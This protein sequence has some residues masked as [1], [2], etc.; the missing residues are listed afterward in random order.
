MSTWFITGSSSGLGRQLALAVLDAGHN[1]VV[2]A[3]SVDSVKDLADIHPHTAL[4]VALD[5]TDRGQ[6]T[7][8]IRL[9]EERFGAIDVLVNNAG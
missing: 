8:A 5:V 9:G 3:R 2:T 6:A 7:E 1:A 4:A